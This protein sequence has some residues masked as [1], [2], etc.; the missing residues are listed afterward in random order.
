MSQSFNKVIL[1]GNLTDDPVFRELKGGGGF[2]T[3]GLAINEKRRTRDG[4]TVEETVFAD[5]KTWGRQ[6]ETCADYL[7]KGSPVFI[8]GSL[9]LDTWESQD[10]KKQSKLRVRASRVQFLGS[11]AKAEDQSEA[12]RPRGQTR[13]R[14]A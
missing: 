10:G 11:G 5:I 8:D 13:R 4:E 14:A 2:T 12:D 1:M 6:A 3:F 9:V 7:Q